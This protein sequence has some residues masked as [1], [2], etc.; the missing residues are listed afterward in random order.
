[1]PS[2]TTTTPP[3]SQQVLCTLRVFDISTR[4]YAI[5]HCPLNV[6]SALL[7]TAIA[8]GKPEAAFLP[9]RT[10]AERTLNSNNKKWTCV[11]CRKPAGKNAVVANGFWERG[12]GES[13]GETSEDPARRGFTR[14]LELVAVPRCDALPAC[15]VAAEKVCRIALEDALPEG[16][17]ARARESE[18]EKTELPAEV[19]VYLPRPDGPGK[20]NE[21]ASGGDD[22]TS[23][24]DL[25]SYPFHLEQSTVSV[26]SSLAQLD[27][28]LGPLARALR[29]ASSILIA[30]AIDSRKLWQCIAC[31]LPTDAYA[32]STAAANREGKLVS[33][34]EIAHHCRPPAE[35]VPNNKDAE[36]VSNCMKQVTA[37]M[38]QSAAQGNANFVGR[39]CSAC[40]KHAARGAPGQGKTEFRKCSAC[41]H[42]YYCSEACQKNDWP[43]HRK[44]CA[45]MAG[46]GG[47]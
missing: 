25:T 40:G 43:K 13:E 2:P 28:D 5:F 15:K 26:P 41:R 14:F 4:D 8:R 16:A 9:A 23:N 22:L 1:M 30:K 45:Q 11:G 47:K 29:D 6:P 18:M 20:D 27:A 42:A 44:A 32:I 31:G 34:V 19:V 33:I 10:W 24:G 21:E 38:R 46:L 36:S 35:A 3:D 7:D 12:K 37:M 39:I 17:L